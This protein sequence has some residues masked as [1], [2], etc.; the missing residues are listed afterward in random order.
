MKVILNQ[1]NKVINPKKKLK[2]RIRDRTCPTLRRTAQEREA[3]EDWHKSHSVGR[4]CRSAEAA[5]V[6]E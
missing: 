5:E 1:G 3:I 4:Q 6:R 2:E